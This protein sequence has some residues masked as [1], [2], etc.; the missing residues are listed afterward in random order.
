MTHRARRIGEKLQPMQEFLNASIH[1]YPLERR[2]QSLWQETRINHPGI[3]PLQ[4]RGSRPPLYW[5]D[6][7]PMFLLAADR[8]GPDQPVLGLHVPASDAVRFRVPYKIEEGAAELVRYLREVQPTGPYHLTGLCI[9]GL[10]AYEMA[11][12]L[13]ADGHEVALLAV[14]DVPGPNDEALQGDGAQAHPRSKANLLLDELWRGGISGL[15][16]FARR[17]STAIARR[18]KLRRWKIQ[19]AVGLKI[20]R[21]RLLNDPDAIEEAASYFSIPRPYSGRIAFLQS[22]DWGGPNQAWIEL[23][24][25]VWEVHRVSGGHISMFN[26]EHVDS[27]V[28]S[29]RICL[30]RTSSMRTEKMATG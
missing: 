1:T 16:G 13:V 27:V 15:P 3:I 28:R 18:L 22:D 2:P 29:L 26:D 11:R 23:L 9:A 4:P 25:G 24:S 5:V 14:F 7:G 21:N 8:L 20:N 17:R 10:I 12:Q 30:A 6:A 19:Q